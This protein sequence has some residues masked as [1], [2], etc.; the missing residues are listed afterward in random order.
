MKY[1][2]V[3]VDDFIRMADSYPSR[4]SEP[5]LCIFPFKALAKKTKWIPSKNIK[6]GGKKEFINR[7]F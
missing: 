5:F 7:N 2:V 4:K 3:Y 1:L 6:K